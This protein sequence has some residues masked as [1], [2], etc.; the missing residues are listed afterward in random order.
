MRRNYSPEFEIIKELV[1]KLF[2]IKAERYFR[3]CLILNL[4]T[5][6][7]MPWVVYLGSK[8]TSLLL[9]TC[10]TFR[11]S[12]HIFFTQLVHFYLTDFFKSLAIFIAN[13]NIDR[14]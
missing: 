10:K 2:F 8:F 9:L 12:L 4:M 11:N 6:G 5:L 13:G 3:E 7:N 14:K 1:W